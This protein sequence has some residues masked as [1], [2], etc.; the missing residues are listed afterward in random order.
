MIEKSNDFSPPSVKNETI[1]FLRNMTVN[2]VQA[3]TSKII[4]TCD[5]ETPHLFCNFATQLGVFEF[6]ILFIRIGTN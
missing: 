6:V 1:G 5:A 4:N 2:P 3:K